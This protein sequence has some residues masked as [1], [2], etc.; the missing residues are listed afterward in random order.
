VVCL[1]EVHKK[2]F[3]IFEVERGL[4]DASKHIFC[5]GHNVLL[6]DE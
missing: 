4:E 1:E 6:L 3:P 5:V 2:A